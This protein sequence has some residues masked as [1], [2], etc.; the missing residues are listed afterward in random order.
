MHECRERGCVTRGDWG[1][2]CQQLTV[3]GGHPHPLAPRDMPFQGGAGVILA[4]S[5]P[6]SH[7]RK[8]HLDVRGMSFTL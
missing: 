6:R 3:G 5:P 8:Q 4:P 1:P 7:G 2:P